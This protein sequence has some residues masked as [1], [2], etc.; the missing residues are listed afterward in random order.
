[1]IHIH[2]SLV[3]SSWFTLST[4]FYGHIENSLN[5]SAYITKVK[6]M[7]QK[8]N[9]GIPEPL[10]YKTGLSITVILKSKS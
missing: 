7:F 5:L 2:K 6:F 3:E 4:D 9:P 1:M 8:T 10:H